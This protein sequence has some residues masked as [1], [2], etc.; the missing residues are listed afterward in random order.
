M[1]E[2]GHFYSTYPPI[3][4]K[5][6]WQRRKATASRKRLDGEEGRRQRRGRRGTGPPSHGGKGRCNAP[7]GPSAGPR[8]TFK[9]VFVSFGP[10]AG[11]KG[12]LRH[13]QG[14]GT[15]VGGRVKVR[16]PSGGWGRGRRE[17]DWGAD[18]FLRFARNDRTNALE[19]TEVALQG[20]RNDRS[21]TAR[22]S[23]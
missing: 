10:S 13:R 4:Q 21:G 15:I 22:R 23:E 14:A 17:A 2:I 20:A 19:M 5:L 6:T 7:F 3:N 1:P 18:R 12:P 8:G 9:A 16:G 11:P